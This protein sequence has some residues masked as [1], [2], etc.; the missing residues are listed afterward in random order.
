MELS[1]VGRMKTGGLRMT[2]ESVWGTLELRLVRI[3]PPLGVLLEPLNRTP[4]HKA[5]PSKKTALE[6]YRP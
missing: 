1:H 2:G 3:P 4:D 6:A 5:K